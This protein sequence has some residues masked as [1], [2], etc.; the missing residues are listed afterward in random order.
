MT[1]FRKFELEVLRLLLHGAVSP[2]Q[3]SFIEDF[4]GAFDYR[5]TGSGYFLTI[6]DPILPAEKSTHHAPAVVGISGDVQCGFVA[7]L[8][9]KRLKLECHTWGP[10]DVPADIRDRAVSI[11]TPPVQFA[12]Q[13]NA[14]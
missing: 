1:V 10:V 11:L 12:D 5:Y 4:S 2:A 8:G 9:K 3:M 7:F 6:F 14:T 13:A